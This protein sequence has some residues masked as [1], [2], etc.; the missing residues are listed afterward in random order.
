M[1]GAG[2][3]WNTVDATKAEPWVTVRSIICAWQA[4]RTPRDFIQSEARAR[5]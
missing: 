3:R 4:E 1:V 2:R 5:L